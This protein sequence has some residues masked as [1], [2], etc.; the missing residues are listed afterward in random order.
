MARNIHP[1]VLL[2]E[3][4]RDIWVVVRLLEK[5]GITWEWGNEPIIQIE[6]PGYPQKDRGGKDKL[7]KSK[8]IASYLNQRGCVALGLLVDADEDASRRWQQVREA[9]R[10]SMPNIPNELPETGLV[11]TT[12]NSGGDAIKF[13]VWIMPDN[14]MR[15]MMENFLVKLIPE[16]MAPLW[17]YAQEVVTEAKILGAPFTDA[18]QDKANIHSWLAWQDPPGLELHQAIIKQVFSPQKAESQIFINWLRDL[19]D[20]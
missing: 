15:G 17:T 4:D 6:Y 2:V 7:L 1:K 13:G 10:F 18:H 12:Q 9:C 11:F 16:G 20:L 14:R 19:Y 5:N 8:F 3:G